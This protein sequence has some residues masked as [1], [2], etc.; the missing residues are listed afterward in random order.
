MKHGKGMNI[1]INKTLYMKGSSKSGMGM[2]THKHQEIG[3]KK[4]TQQI[5]DSVRACSRNNL[6]TPLV[7]KESQVVQRR[8]KSKKHGINST[9]TQGITQKRSSQ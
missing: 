8:A 9:N 7:N 1:N 5:V 4:Q 2:D 6:M 3:A